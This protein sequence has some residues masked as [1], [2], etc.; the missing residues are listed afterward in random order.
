MF[1][2]G[3]PRN[4]CTSKIWTYTVVH[5]QKWC[6]WCTYMLKETEVGEWRGDLWLQF[7]YWEAEGLTLESV[8]QLVHDRGC[9][10]I[11]HDITVHNVVLM[12]KALSISHWAVISSIHNVPWYKYMCTLYARLYLCTYTLYMWRCCVTCNI[13]E[14]KGWE[15]KWSNP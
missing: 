9:H 5:V 15:V 12:C 13:T 11:A 7:V 6:T 10:M 2:N 8:P 14:L 1:E 3:N 4:L